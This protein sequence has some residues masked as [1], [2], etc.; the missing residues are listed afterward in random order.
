[1]TPSTESDVNKFLNSIHLPGIDKPISDVGRVLAV[2]ETDGR[3]EASIELGF[4][5]AGAHDEYRAHI[6]AELAAETGCDAIEIELTTRVV[7]VNVDRVSLAVLSR[8]ALRSL[9][10]H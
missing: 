4:P 5:A 6:A 8:P 9:S 2:A 3:I 1:M 7:A 10:C